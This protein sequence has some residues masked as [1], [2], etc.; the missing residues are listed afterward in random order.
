MVPVWS[1][2]I[3]V[4]QQLTS[5]HVTRPTAAPQDDVGETVGPGDNDL[6][7]SFATRGSR[8]QIPSA[9]P[10]VLVK[11][12]VYPSISLF[13]ILES[14]APQTAHKVR[15]ELTDVA[16]RRSQRRERLYLIRVRSGAGR[17]RLNRSTKQRPMVLARD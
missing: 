11:A 6:T 5:H 16:F 3:Y 13:I 7:A 9:P 1:T 17:S 4:S 15:L 12:I 8:V 14:C 2:L 10:N